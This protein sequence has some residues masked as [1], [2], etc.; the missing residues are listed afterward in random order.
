MKGSVNG[1]LSKRR[2][3]Q[4]NALVQLS[5][6]AKVNQ[7]ASDYRKKASANG[8]YSRRKILFLASVWGKEGKQNVTI[9]TRLL[10][11]SCRGRKSVH[12]CQHQVNAEHP[13]GHAWGHLNVKTSLEECVTVCDCKRAKHVATSQLRKMR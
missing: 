2:Q 8:R 13:Q 9:K 11:G 5:A 3:V 4:V 12:G 1:V 6:T 7:F 10:A